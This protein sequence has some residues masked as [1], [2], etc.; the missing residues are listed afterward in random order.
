MKVWL[1]TLIIGFLV[2]SGFVQKTNAE[3][4]L[5]KDNSTNMR[6][7]TASNHD[8]TWTVQDNDGITSNETIEIRFD[9]GYDLTG[10]D[11]ADVDIFDD[12]VSLIIGTS[13]VTPIQT[14]FSSSD[15][16][17]NLTLCPGVTIA[18]GSLMQVKIGTNAYHGAHQIISPD[19]TESNYV[20]LAGQNGYTDT[21]RAQLPAFSNQTTT[22]QVDTLAGDVRFIGKASPGALV[23]FMEFGSV[24]GTQLAGTDSSFDKTIYNVNEG[25]HTFSIYALATN[26]KTTLTISFNINIIGNSTI[27]V[28]G[29]ILPSMI[30]L[31]TDKIRRPARLN[32]TGMGIGNSTV[33]IFI[34][35]SRDNQSFNVSTDISGTW[36]A[37]FNPKLHLGSKN[38]YSMVL[39]GQGGQSPLS[40]TK[41]YDVLISADLNNDSRTNITDFSIL[42]FSYSKKVIPNVVSDIN[43]NN[44]VDLVDFSIMMSRWT[45]G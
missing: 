12:G 14:I 30:T 21:G 1:I 10:L 40:Q 33:Q 38:T 37:N 43:D 19:A 2:L 26:S 8:I 28:S 4:I 34:T 44:I 24:V 27:I 23:Y 17:T 29:L 13:C 18:T 5:L 32:G 6:P 22:L 3:N 39:D 16:A 7:A 11:Y 45:G 41:T 25:I 31:D 15:H 20:Y 42:M 36:T 35:G 9:D